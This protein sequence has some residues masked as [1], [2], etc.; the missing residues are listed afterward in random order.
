MAD[1][2]ETGAN[3]ESRR[4]AFKS[5]RNPFQNTNARVLRK[6]EFNIRNVSEFL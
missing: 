4:A 3:E 2:D 6:L 5:Y 1:Q